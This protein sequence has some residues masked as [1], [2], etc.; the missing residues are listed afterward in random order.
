MNFSW[1]IEFISVKIINNYFNRKTH[2]IYKAEY[3]L[4][5]FFSNF[6]VRQNLCI[7]RQMFK[8]LTVDFSLDSKF[9]KGPNI[10]RRKPFYY[11]FYFRN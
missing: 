2:L 11:F 7:N 3:S 4:G 10:P 9:N 8:F 6:K 5:H 1:L